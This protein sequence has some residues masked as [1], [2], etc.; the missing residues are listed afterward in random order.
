MAIYKLGSKGDEVRMIQE[1]LQALGI[2]LGPLDGIFGGG[3]EA[4]VK[5]FQK[6]DGL[7]VDGIVGTATWGRLL[8]GEPLR[9]GIRLQSLD[10]R[11]LALTGSFET[12]AGIPDCFAGI[13]GDF[14]GQGISFGVLQ[15]NFGQGSLQPLLKRM[16][17][18]YPDQ[19]RAVF[20]D[21]F[22]L[23]L[24]RL[25]G[26]KAELMSF[27]RSIQHPVRHFVTEPWRG[28]F[29]SLGRTTE[30]QRVELDAAGNLFRAARL[31]CGEYGLWSERATALMFD[32]KV[33]NGSISGAVKES[34][35]SDFQTIP[36]SLGE[37]DAEVERMR[38]VANR[39]ADAAKVRWRE[40]VR[41]RK[42]CIANGRGIVHGIPYDLEEQFGIGQRPVA[43]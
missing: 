39:R 27:A 26:G 28:M 41:S 16:L 21:S 35:L 8:G 17:T 9:P 42:L 6:R 5:N 38:I 7:D 43:A 1:R 37:E 11:C 3:T 36:P 18:E 24:S 29:K 23:L 19:S 2:Y 33:Q 15:W 22:D 10:Y 32:I 12:G 4:A 25:N 30:F 34:I 13:S 20:H 14:D 31:L 40:D